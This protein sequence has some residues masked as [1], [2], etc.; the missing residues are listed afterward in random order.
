MEYQKFNY[1]KEHDLI[2]KYNKTKLNV[3]VE[4]VKKERKWKN[5]TKT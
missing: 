5:D 1:R 2:Y 4:S 3:L